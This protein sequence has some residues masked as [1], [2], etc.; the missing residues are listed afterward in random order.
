M[1]A[2]WSGQDLD[3][4]HRAAATRARTSASKLGRGAGIEEGGVKVA[5]RWTMEGHH[6][7]YGILEQLGPPPA[8]ACR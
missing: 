2:P 1:A 4:D 5:V 7:G 3:D 6:L 8:N